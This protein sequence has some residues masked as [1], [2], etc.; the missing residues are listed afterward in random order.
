MSVVP[1]A[2]FRT[3]T[4]TFTSDLDLQSHES[5]GHISVQP[6][7]FN[8]EFYYPYPRDVMTARVLVIDPCLCV[9][10]SHAG[11]VSKQMNGSS[12]FLRTGFSRFMLHCVV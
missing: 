5:Y 11:I 2:V 12:S 8:I 3:E 7:H 6:S 10:P 9:C 4:L 1:S